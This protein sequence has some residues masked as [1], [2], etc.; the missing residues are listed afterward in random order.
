MAQ[1]ANQ[2]SFASGEWAPKLRSRVDITKYHAGAALLRN[3]FVDYS[4]GGA[5]TRQ[6]TMF[7]NQCKSLGARLVPFQPSTT[8]SYVLEFGST[9]IRFYSNGAPI[10]EN[11][12][13][14][15]TAASGDTFTITNTY[16]VGDWV[17]ALDWGGLTNVNGNYYIVA[18]ASG[19]AITVTDLFGNTPTFAG[20][21]TSGGQ[22]QRVYTLVSPYLAE[23]L[24][25]NPATGNP[26]IKFA[27]DVTSLIIC[28]PNY[29]PQILTIVSANNWTLTTIFFGPTIGIP[30][31]ITAST[32]LPALASGWNYSYTVTAVDNNGQESAAGV[33]G[34]I[35]AHDYI[36]TT[37]GTNLIQ[38]SPVPGAA[39]YNVYKTSPSYNTAIQPGAQYGFIGN[40][41]GNTFTDAYPGIG[42]DFSQTPPIP[43]NPF[44]GAGVASYTVTN[45]GTY[46]VVPSVTVAQ[47]PDGA[48]AT[49]SASLG[50]TVA[51]IAGHGVTN[52]DIEI[53]GTS[54]S[55]VGFQLT[56]KYGI[57]LNITSATLRLHTGTSYIW[58]V[59]GVSIASPG[60]VTG[61]GTLTPTNPVSPIGCN[62]PGF[63]AFY[64]G[65][66]LRFTFTWG[67]TQVISISPGSDYFIS[68]AVSFSSGLASAIAVLATASAGNP[69]VPAFLQERLW[70][71]AQPQAVQTINISQPTAFF[72]FN[73]SNPS[74]ADDAI[75]ATIIGEELNDIRWMISVPTGMIAGTGKGPWLVNGGGGIATINPITPSNTTAQPQTFNGAN[76]LR[77]IKIG[78]DVLYCT[79]KGSY[80]RDLAYN[81]YAAIFTG[82]DITTL[83]NHLFF[84]HYLLDWA[85]SEEPFKTVWAIRDDGRLLSLAYVKDQDLVGW[86]HHDTDGQFTSVCSVI[87]T[88]Q[89]GNV[90]D[91][92][93]VIAQRT[94]NG[95]TV[96]YV[97]RMADRYFTH[98]YIDAWS[99]D[100]ALQTV[101][102]YTS[103][104]G[105]LQASGISGSVTLTVTN[106]T[107]FNSGM[108]G[109]RVDSQDG[110]VYQ[111]TAYTSSTV[112]TATVIRPPN[113][114]NKY[115]DVPY[116][117]AVGDWFVWEPV[118][119]VTGLTQLEGQ[120]VYGVADGVAV[121]PLT[122]SASGSVTL[123]TAASK[124]TLGLQYLPQ[125]RTLPLDLGEPTTQGKR[126][127]ITALTL[128]VADTLGLEAGTTF[129][130]VVP[131]KDF[132]LGNIPT[133]SSGPSTISDLVNPSTV[134]A[135]DAGDPSTPIDG[136][137]IIDQDWQEAGS[138]CVQQNLPYP[139]T[140]LGVM[141]EVV[142]GDTPR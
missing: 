85:Y 128:R 11:A 74:E 105:T 82:S 60:S 58:E 127:K 2:T 88:V 67:A 141:P 89:G 3:F 46:T 101:P 96:Q 8:L 118:T 140:I 81:I 119:T 116:L 13:T 95:E 136:R 93:Y 120:T 114:Y 50:V 106:D 133:T 94:V 126:K 111:I 56:F 23:D 53:I 59:T 41:E 33:A 107:P 130:N 69:G 47:A 80:I 75:Q 12:V 78:F 1:P 43:E 49:G 125:L 135:D 45:N 42:P 18:T 17:Y 134:D 104:T 7:V 122:V 40:V 97:E 86:A 99:V 14:G 117:Q 28:H 142:V 61:I 20:S 109:W 35:T 83:A 34:T 124:V 70:L 91:A 9:Y 137:L 100:C 54:T 30:S 22:L 102:N 131:V 15:G 139:A 113:N 112:V 62:A 51:T 29:A 71:A 19:S 57:V 32:T 48:Q 92:I 121:G 66:E 76:D 31:A 108:T 90:V 98:G 5:S 63:R 64:T 38:W 87:E 10:L 129:A 36:G 110:A 132:Q 65:P 115:T 21:Y 77:P 25:P 16:A 39:S 79:N 73:V 26:G 84:D 123:S 138:Y 68:P 55:P 6:G 27:Q 24:F 52:Y 44:A 37:V 4:G 103:T 72:N